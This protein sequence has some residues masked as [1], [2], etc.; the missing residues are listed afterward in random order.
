MPTDE[1]NE[2]TEARDPQTVS[3][4]LKRG[5][6]DPARATA[7]VSQAAT[8]QPPGLLAQVIVKF[9]DPSSLASLASTAVGLWMIVNQPDREPT[10]WFLIGAGG[11]LVPAVGI[12]KK[13]AGMGSSK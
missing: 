12:A 3:V 4:E 8:S 2:P 13:V 1:T 7:T 6:E 9:I 10:A 11:L 5:G